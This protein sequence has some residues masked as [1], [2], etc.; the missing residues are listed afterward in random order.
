MLMNVKE[1]S[2]VKEESEKEYEDL[3]GDDEYIRKKYKRSFS[4][5]DL[6]NF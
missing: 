3:L 6:S 4:A 2:D 5:N 1:E